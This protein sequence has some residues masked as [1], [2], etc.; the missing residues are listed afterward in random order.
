MKHIIPE[1]HHSDAMEKVWRPADKARAA[2]R[3]RPSDEKTRTEVGPRPNLS[4]AKTSGE[5]P[6]AAR[7]G[8]EKN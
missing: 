7:S 4:E 5:W 2:K 1:E 3:D 6:I 8:E